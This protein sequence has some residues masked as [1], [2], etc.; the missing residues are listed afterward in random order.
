MLVT[1]PLTW[2]TT[3]LRDCAIRIVVVGK[4]LARAVP[5]DWR[6]EFAIRFVDDGAKRRLLSQRVQIGID[7]HDRPV[8][9][10]QIQPMPLPVTPVACGMSINVVVQKRENLPLSRRTYAR[11]LLIVVWWI[12]GRDYAMHG[13]P[14]R[15]VDASKQLPVGD[16]HLD[17][18]ARCVSDNLLTLTLVLGTTP[19]DVRLDSSV[20]QS[21]FE[22][23][24]VLNSSYHD[25]YVSSSL[26]VGDHVLQGQVVS[27]L[28]FH[29]LR[30]VRVPAIE[31]RTELCI[32]DSHVKRYLLRLSL[33]GYRSDD[34]LDDDVTTV[35][36][37]R[38]GRHPDLVLGVEVVDDRRTA[39][40][41]E[42]MNLVDDHKPELVTVLLELGSIGVEFL[43]SR[44]HDVELLELGPFHCI[45]D[46]LLAVFAFKLSDVRGASES[47]F[48]LPR[49]VFL[50]HENQG[51]QPKLANQRCRG[52]CLSETRRTFENSVQ[53]LVHQLVECL[54]LFRTKRPTSRPIFL[55][56][57]EEL[58]GVAE[59]RPA[60]VIHD[61]EL[62]GEDL[63][64]LSQIPA[65]ER[66][67]VLANL[68]RLDDEIAAFSG[69]SVLV[70]FVVV[71]LDHV[72]ELFLHR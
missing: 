64:D 6:A 18:A 22:P 52:Y 66:H 48:E 37:L 36:A 70:G 60:P 39:F 29:D 62:L 12:R 56:H 20:E 44:N 2:R 46:E 42:S 55:L 59:L 33:Y 34:V 61:L 50:I 51:L 71:V 23:L 67:V 15:H 25:Q 24:H 40:A 5:V 11:E 35:L 49:K 16:S 58:H 57:A 8:V 9:L 32:H 30:Y 31:L 7:E 53:K 38:R 19:E 45:A 17:L 10:V 47:G 27:G 13:I 21:L 26:H 28:G 43:P 3:A 68:V 1:I 72:G 4:H 63:F 69:F 54:N 14:E 41:C 65:L